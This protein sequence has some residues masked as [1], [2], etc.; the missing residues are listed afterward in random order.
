[1]KKVWALV[2]N[3]SGII[4][5]I[6]LEES[7]DGLE[8]LERYTSILSNPILLKDVS[9]NKK[10]QIGSA[11]DPNTSSFVEGELERKATDSPYAFAIVQDNS[12][13][14]I[15]KVWTEKRK[16]L[17]NIAE[18]EGVIAVDCTDM[19]YSN[20]KIGMSWDGTQFKE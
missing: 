13:K 15:I 16:A 19:E 12:V 10:V 2:T 7:R 18:S 20:L 11:W 17:F 9:N 6:D 1:M 8:R 4:E 14:G 3:T 5:F